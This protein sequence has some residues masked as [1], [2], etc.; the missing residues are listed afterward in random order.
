VVGILSAAPLTL[1]LGCTAETSHR[2]ARAAGDTAVA[3]TARVRFEPKFFT[4]PEYETVSVLADIVLPRDRRSGSATDAGVPEF[5]DFMMADQET[6]AED[7]TAMRGGLAWLDAECHRRFGKRFIDCATRE[8]M[9]LIDQIAWPARAKPEMSQGVAFFNAFRD[10]TAFGFWS[11]EM[12]VKDLRYQGNAV[13]PEWTGCPEPALRKLGVR[14]D[15][16]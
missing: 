12:G 13:V 5:M 10:L 15:D 11:S 8:R 4:A 6:S 7:R 14:Y 16:K 2:V 3:R 9:A 1:L